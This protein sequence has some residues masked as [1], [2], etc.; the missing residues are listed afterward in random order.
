M[1]IYEISEICWWLSL[2]YYIVYFHMCV[3]GYVSS[4]FTVKLIPIN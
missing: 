2:Y 1:F 4:V 3:V